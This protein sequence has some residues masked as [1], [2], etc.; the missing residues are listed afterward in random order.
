MGDDAPGLRAKLAVAEG[1]VVRRGQL[2]FEDRAH[3]GIR[4]TAPGAGRVA[5]IFR[6]HRRALRSVVIQLSE[7][8]R[9]GSPTEGELAAFASWSPDDPEGWSG[10]RV[11]E[12]LV[13]SGLWVAL[14]AR[15]YGRVA[16]PASEPHALFVTAIDTNPHAPYPE[17]VV[18]ESR[19]DFERGLRLLVKLCAGTSYLCVS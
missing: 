15:P 18:G 16:D 13:E 2:L 19:E 14:R 10:R 1:D 4:Y 17:L 6:G 7:S 5:A 11:R 3:P 12:L 9:G 8:E